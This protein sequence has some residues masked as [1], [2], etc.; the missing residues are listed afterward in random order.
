MSP[1]RAGWLGTSPSHIYSLVSGSSQC[2]MC[3]TPGT[4]HLFSPTLG[5]WDG[6]FFLDEQ[7]R[8]IQTAG[9]ELISV[10]FFL[11]LSSPV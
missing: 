2:S 5:S 8:T 10:Y 1:E 4:E 3:D 11:P 6:V 9:L 7:T